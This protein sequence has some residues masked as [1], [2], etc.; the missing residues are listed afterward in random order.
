MNSAETRG[1]AVAGACAEKPFWTIGREREKLYAGQFVKAPDQQALLFPVIDAALD[2]NEGAGDEAE[3]IGLATRAMSKGGSAVWEDTACWISK[4]SARFPDVLR[5]WDELASD[6]AWQVR[7][8]VACLLY[9][10][11]PAAQSDRLFAVLRHDRSV[12]VHET[13]VSR[14]EDRVGSANHVVFKMFDA[15]DPASPGF[16]RG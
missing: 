16:N 4:L 6:P 12:K 1:T 13:A 15:N 8:R 7:W 9:T 3:F 11:I 5:L 10:H 14:Y 2:L